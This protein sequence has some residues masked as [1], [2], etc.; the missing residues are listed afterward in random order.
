M[1][2]KSQSSQDLARGLDTLTQAWVYKVMLCTLPLPAFLLYLGFPKQAVGAWTCFGILLV[3][4]KVYWQLRRSVLFWV[5]V[6]V[7]GLLQLPLILYVPWMDKYSSRAS[8]LP[9]ALA[10]FALICGLMWLVEKAIS[11]KPAR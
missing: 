8:L 9:L 1:E 2:S 6:L 4:V 7:S 3:A 10:D 5:A 11:S